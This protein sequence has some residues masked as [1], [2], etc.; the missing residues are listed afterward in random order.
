MLEPLRRK[1]AAV[2]EGKTEIIAY[3]YVYVES[4]LDRIK[5]I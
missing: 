2:I 5:T 1:K 4:Y 3:L